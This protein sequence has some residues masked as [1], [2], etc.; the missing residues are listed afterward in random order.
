MAKAGDI[1]ENPI[2]GERITFKDRRQA[3]V[4]KEMKGGVVAASVL[5]TFGVLM[6]IWRRS[7]SSRR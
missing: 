7:H 1:I 3:V 5:L 4:S 6:L 2:T